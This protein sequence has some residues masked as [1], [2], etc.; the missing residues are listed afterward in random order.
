MSLTLASLWPISFLTIA[1]IDDLCFRKFH[2]W[3]FISLSLVGLWYVFFFSELTTLDALGGFALGGALMLP[4]ALIK[5][6]GAGDMKF[7]M[8]FGIIM[9]TT[10]T[11][12]VFIYALFWGALIGVLQ[13]LLAGKIKLLADNLRG[14]AYKLIPTETQKTPYTV[15][16]LFGWLSYNQWGGLFT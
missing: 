5:A 15:A 2:N 14:F 9:G 11:F 3:L 16:I 4:L 6:I 10:A 12:E 1:V 7:M 13:S 8:C